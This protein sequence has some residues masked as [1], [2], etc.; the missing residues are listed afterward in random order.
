MSCCDHIAG[1][2][3]SVTIVACDSD[4][5]DTNTYTLLPC[6]L[7]PRVTADARAMP[8][9][10]RA[11]HLG[12]AQIGKL[13]LDCTTCGVE[14]DREEISTVHSSGYCSFD[15]TGAERRSFGP[16]LVQCKPSMGFWAQDFT[17]SSPSHLLHLCHPD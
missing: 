2:L 10:A 4:E 1:G 5:L 12:S 15:D 9:V 3:F 8:P 17:R 16:L 11:S 13:A 14:R 6:V 7:R